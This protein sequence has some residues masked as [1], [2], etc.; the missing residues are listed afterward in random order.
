[1]LNERSDDAS[2]N[3]TKQML[4][5]QRGGTKYAQAGGP[6]SPVVSQAVR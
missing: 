6:V 3:S 4:G 2:L 1:M 5:Q